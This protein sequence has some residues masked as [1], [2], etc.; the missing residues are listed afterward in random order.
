MKIILAI[1]ILLHACIHLLGIVKW[2]GLAN[3]SQLSAI[4]RTEAV[5]WLLGFVLLLASVI[6]WMMHLPWFWAL[7]FAG[8][9][10][11]QVLIFYHWAEAK[12]G[13]WFN[14][15]WLIVALTS[16][17][18]YFFNQKTERLHAVFLSE[19]DMA[20]ETIKEEDIKHLPPPVQNWLRKCGIIGRQTINYAW[21]TQELSMKLT[22]D[23]ENGFSAK[24]RQLI[25]T[26]TPAFI[27]DVSLSM[28][29]I[30]PVQGRDMF[31]HGTGSMKISLLST[32]PVVNE[33]PS[34]PLNEGSFQRYL[35]EI[36]WVPS[37]ALSPYITWEEID[38]HSAR[39]TL[40]YMGTKGSGVFTFDNE[41]H[42]SS[43][44]TWRFMGND[45]Q[46]KEWIIQN[47]E[48]KTFHGITIPG[49]SEAIWKLEEGD[50]TWLTLEI[51]DIQYE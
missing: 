20:N 18:S 6:G 47:K 22:P 26:Q 40:D 10:L 16:M 24:A 36:V 17:M 11:S 43:F 32:F 23:Q 31:H 29:S 25:T 14:T 34:I 9:I 37:A 12:H 48:N 4:S 3:I 28:Y 13:T 44:K 15:I 21:L 38:E 8:I 35:G 30:L 27:W 5:L 49:I 46:R 50:W 51:T 1:L 19:N 7:A 39:A 41:G 45:D 33:S 42:L 2:S